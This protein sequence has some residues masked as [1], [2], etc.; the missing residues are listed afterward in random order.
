MKKKMKKVFIAL[1]NSRGTP[2]FGICSLNILYLF[3]LVWTR[4][5]C[6]TGKKQQYF[7]VVWVETLSASMYLHYR[8]KLYTIRKTGTEEVLGGIDIPEWRGSWWEEDAVLCWLHCSRCR[9]CESWSSPGSGHGAAAWATSQTSPPAHIVT[10]TF[11]F[12]LLAT[13]SK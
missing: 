5:V 3:P 8:E 6:P 10:E 9:P 4:Q 13:F 1:N 12:F 2:L 7:S 11:F